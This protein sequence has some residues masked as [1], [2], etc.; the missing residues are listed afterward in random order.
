MDKIKKCLKEDLNFLVDKRQE[1]II[2]DNNKKA[3]EYTRLIKDTIQIMDIYKKENESHPNDTECP[4]GKKIL[5]HIFKHR[6]ISNII[7]NTYYFESD[8]IY[9]TK[10]SVEKL[11]ID[12]I[13]K[14]G[15]LP[16]LVDECCI[17]RG[18]GKST[19]LLDIYNIL[20]SFG[21]NVKIIQKTKYEDCTFKSEDVINAIDSDLSSLRGMRADFYLIR[22]NNFKKQEVEKII[23]LIRSNNV[24]GF[25]NSGKSEYSIINGV[26]SNLK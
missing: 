18:V 24:F 4:V 7:S 15:L 21:L 14:L 6:D 22:D 26:L 5:Y 23:D 17:C 1:Y 13:D 19:I 8:N 10:K 20:K 11:I 12:K 16:M 2:S 3:I 9:T 25:F